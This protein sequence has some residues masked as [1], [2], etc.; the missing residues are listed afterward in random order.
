MK[1]IQ[2]VTDDEGRKTAVLIDLRK[3]GELWEDIYDS[4]VA[5][6]RAAEPRESLEK[7]KMLLKKQGKLDG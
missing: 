7:V 5:Q 1:G 2:F 4:L 3:Y 6:R